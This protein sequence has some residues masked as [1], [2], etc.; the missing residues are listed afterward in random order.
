M[1]LNNSAED[2]TFSPKI[3]R[4][5][6]EFDS[7]SARW[8]KW[9]QRKAQNLE[10]IRVE[11]SPSFSLSSSAKPAKW[12][13]RLYDDVERI[14]S[15]K[16]KK[17][18]LQ[19][20]EEAKARQVI[21]NE[22]TK[23]YATQF[24][25]RKY[26]NFFQ[27]Q[28][29]FNPETNSLP[30]EQAIECFKKILGISQENSFLNELLELVQQPEER[31]FDL[32]RF[33]KL[34]D[35]AILNNDES[36]QYREGFLFEFYENF[37]IRSDFSRIP[38]KAEEYVLNLSTSI[39]DGV[40]DDFLRRITLSTQHSQRKKKV[41]EEKISKEFLQTYTFQPKINSISTTRFNRQNNFKTPVHARLYDYDLERRKEHKEKLTLEKLRSEERLFN[42][43][44][45]FS[46][47]L[48]PRVNSRRQ[49]Q[50]QIRARSTKSPQ[51][52]T[53]EKVPVAFSK[54][55]NSEARIIIQK[56]QRESS[57]IGAT[58]VPVVKNE[59]NTTQTIV[60]PIQ[61]NLDIPKSP[62]S[63]PHSGVEVEI[64]LSKEKTLIFQMKNG[65]EPL[66]D[67]YLD[68]IHHCLKAY[69][70]LEEEKREIQQAL[71]QIFFEQR[72]ANQ[73]FLWNH[74]LRKWES[75]LLV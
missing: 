10:K 7:Q 54:P 15:K 26:S 56:E 41:L 49:V 14:R 39:I 58:V 51:I 13:G 67:K 35:E 19:K 44:C 75:S 25:K 52:T 73:V 57:E 23:I 24:W 55:K 18:T 36:N 37:L 72:S 66:K 3:N 62:D 63:I 65:E 16:E 71:Q 59:A 38:E 32:E 27:N 2:F 40:N 70:L 30:L 53:S 8:E 61:T 45:S 28:K 6:K 33:L 17:I 1:L 47:I 29:K 60:G 9:N 21:T 22:K 4:S 69:P 74:D 64:I 5:K 68:Q 48:T 42:E 12:T 31:N 50:F 43:T 20:V 34:I 11:T 46:P